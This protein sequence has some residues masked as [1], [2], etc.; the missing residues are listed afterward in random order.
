MGF[1]L[2][3]GIGINRGQRA[4]LS[5]TVASFLSGTNGA[6]WDWADSATVFENDAGTDA[7]EAGDVLAV[8][9]ASI[10][11]SVT[12]LNLTR[13]AASTGCPLW[14]STYAQFD[15]SNDYIDG[16]SNTRSIFQAAPAAFFGAR[17][18][19]NSLAA[20]RHL[21]GWTTAS[22]AFYR[23]GIII[24]AT[25]AINVVYR[26]LDADSQ[27]SRFTAEGL[28]T[29]GT[30]Y[31]LLSWLDYAN[32]GAGALKVVLDGVE[33]MSQTLTGTGNTENTQSARV[34]IGSALNGLAEF[35]D[36]DYDRLIVAPKLASASERAA[37]TDWLEWI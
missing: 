33:V 12:P 9:K 26:R 11:G 5:K 32:G 6:A 1:G 22:T 8:T 7:C 10:L 27:T 25:G 24:T 13:A 34:R 2:G 37:I 20:S 15:G 36:I 30:T 28:I 19:L 29:T 14:Q 35:S 17:F 3:I 4:G 21:G 31:T 16:D 18:S 23:F